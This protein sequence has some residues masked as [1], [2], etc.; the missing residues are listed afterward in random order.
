M[1]C[2]TRALSGTAETPALPIKGLILLPSLRNKFINFTNK[3]P[4][5]VAMI[6][7]R[8]P[9][10]NIPK[11][12]DVK[13]VVACVEAPT[14][15]PIRIVTISISEPLAVSANRFPSYKLQAFH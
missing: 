13:N 1:I 12:C 14:V 4:P 15:K 9:N 8:A 10:A 6:K 3:I 7:E 2:E 11:D 5:A